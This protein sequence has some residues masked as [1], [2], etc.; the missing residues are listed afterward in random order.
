M[1]GA[2]IEY[3]NNFYRKYL[4]RPDPLKSVYSTS[5]SRKALV[6]D[7]VGTKEGTC[8]FCARKDC[9]YPVS[10][11]YLCPRCMKGGHWEYG[12]VKIVKSGKCAIC[13]LEFE[14]AGVFVQS[15]H[16]C[17]RCLWVKLGKKRGALRTDGGRL[18]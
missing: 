9:I 12:A 10:S 13:G 15:S 6:A 3:W 18:V 1:S 5:Q 7:G 17:I 14:G 4:Y 8:N 2:D 11:V 16:S